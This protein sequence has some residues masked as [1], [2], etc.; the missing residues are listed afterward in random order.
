MLRDNHLFT[1]DRDIL[2]PCLTDLTYS[3]A[4]GDDLN[5][6]AVVEL[7]VLEGDD[8]QDEEDDDDV[9]EEIPSVNRSIDM[10]SSLDVPSD[11]LCPGSM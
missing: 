1:F 4:P 2:I 5:K 8:Y 6:D 10:N 11:D 9:E 7:L 3:Y